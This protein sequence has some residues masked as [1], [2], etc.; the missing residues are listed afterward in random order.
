METLT[1]AHASTPERKCFRLIGGVLVEKTVGEVLPSLKTQLE[2]LQQILQTLLKQYN[3]R[4]QQLG[5][6][7]Q[8]HGIVPPNQQ[9]QQQAAIK[10]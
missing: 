3:E 9:Q 8:E 2:G 4:Q 5:A 10:A 6:F 7:V 1:D